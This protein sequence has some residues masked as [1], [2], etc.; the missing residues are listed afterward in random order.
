MD[1]YISVSQYISWWLLDS[2][3]TGTYKGLEGYTVAKIHV[4]SEEQS[5]IQTSG[6][7]GPQTHV[8]RFIPYC[9]MTD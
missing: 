3:H 8:F 4:A 7:T 5:R 9:I 2:L 1:L 6:L